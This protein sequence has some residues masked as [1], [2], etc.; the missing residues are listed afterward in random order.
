MRVRTIPLGTVLAVVVLLGVAALWAVNCSGPRASASDLSV[1]PPTSAN[2]AYQM[3]AAIHNAGPGHGQVQVTFRLR[4]KRGG[5]TYE[6]MQ[7]VAL[8]AGETSVVSAQITA[9][10][11]DYTPEVD[12]A[13]PPG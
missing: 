6:Q 12:V 8:D 13:Y 4:D 11:G 5:Q 3:S 7:T 2:T 10:P 9:P 1:Q